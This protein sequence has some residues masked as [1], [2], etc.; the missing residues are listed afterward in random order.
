MRTGALVGAIKICVWRTRVGGHVIKLCSRNKYWPAYPRMNLRTLYHTLPTL[1]SIR[2]ANLRTI[3]LDRL[4]DKS[5]VMSHRAGGFLR[6]QVTMQEI[7]GANSGEVGVLRTEFALEELWKL[8]FPDM[9]TNWPRPSA[10]AAGSEGRYI[11]ES[12]G[13]GERFFHGPSTPRSPPPSPVKSVMPSNSDGS[14]I[15][16]WKQ[17]TLSFPL[18]QY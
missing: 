10:H 6:R 7:C 8:D 18:H 5:F 11:S 15:T 4:S 16:V 12:T 2:A 13:D 14:Y 3:P 17:N 9:E 1:A